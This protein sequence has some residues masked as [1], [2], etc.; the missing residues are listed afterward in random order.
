[1]SSAIPSE[2]GVQ[3]SSMFI[4]CK[5]WTGFPFNIIIFIWSKEKKYN[6]GHSSTDMNSIGLGLQNSAWYSCAQDGKTE[7]GGNKE[8]EATVYQGFV[9][10]HQMWTFGKEPAMPQSPTFHLIVFLSFLLW[11]QWQTSERVTHLQEKV[12]Q[13]S[14]AHKHHVSVFCGSFI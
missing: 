3:F 2:Q 12:Q 8:G 1:M 14:Q 7:C 6:G 10:R 11:R 13:S 4:F 5:T 9:V